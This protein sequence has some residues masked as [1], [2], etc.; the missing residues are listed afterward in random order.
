MNRK[1]L[2]LLLLAAAHANAANLY[3]AT[4]PVE[5]SDY[6]NNPDYQRFAETCDYQVNIQTDVR[7]AKTNRP[8]IDAQLNHDAPKPEELKKFI[9]DSIKE[10]YEEGSDKE[11]L[12]SASHNYE[13]GYTPDY[14]GHHGAQA[15]ADQHRHTGFPGSPGSC[16][17]SQ[18]G[19]GSPFHGLPAE[20]R[21]MGMKSRQGNVEIPRSHQTRI[22]AD[23]RRHN[24]SGIPRN[25]EPGHHFPNSDGGDE[26]WSECA[27][28]H[29]S[30]SF[31]AGVLEGATLYLGRAIWS[32]LLT[33][34]KASW[35]PRLPFVG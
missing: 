4:E 14:L 26:I 25:T 3:F 21:S 17:V 34:G 8:K 29:S 27:H 16:R 9:I 35:L 28:S 22:E 20:C 13:T 23:P 10:F 24:I 6:F 30:G 31:G 32:T 1:I 18:D 33:T 12:C 19:N 7:K 15:L 11:S 5:A 2:A